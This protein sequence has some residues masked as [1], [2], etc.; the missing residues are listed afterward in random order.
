LTKYCLFTMSSDYRPHYKSIE[1]IIDKKNFT[2]NDIAFLKYSTKSE[3]L[4][5]SNP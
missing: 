4:V 5:I 1:T 2:N 3:L